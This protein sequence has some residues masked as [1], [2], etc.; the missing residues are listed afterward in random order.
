MVIA[1]VYWVHP[2]CHTQCEVT[3]MC[4]VIQFLRPQGR[5]ASSCLRKPRLR[6][7]RDPPKV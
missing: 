1:N 7:T 5:G 4:A 6:V 3:H 2:T